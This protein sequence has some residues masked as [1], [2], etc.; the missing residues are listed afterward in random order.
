MIENNICLIWPTSI[1]AGGGRVV[2]DMQSDSPTLAATRKP[3][4]WKSAPMLCSAVGATILCRKC[5]SLEA[6]HFRGGAVKGFYSGTPGA[7]AVE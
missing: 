3:R 5:P 2:T 4:R 1:A 6:G 7:P